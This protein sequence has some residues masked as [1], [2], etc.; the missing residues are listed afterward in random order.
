MHVMRAE[1]RK[2]DSAVR[3]L[4]YHLSVHVWLCI[5]IGWKACSFS[6]HRAKP[7]LQESKPHKWPFVWLCHRF[8]VLT[9]SRATRAVDCNL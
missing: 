2:A 1:S 5:G 8:I 4:P 6:L 7:A 9:S 3:R